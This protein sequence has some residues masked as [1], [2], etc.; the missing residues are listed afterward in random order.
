MKL[1]I[2]GAGRGKR[3]GKFT[4]RKPKILVKIGKLSLL[5]ILLK[6]STNTK[7]F[8]EIVVVVGY[9]KKDVQKLIVKQGFKN[10]R[11]IHNPFYEIFGP[12]ISL[13]LASLFI[14]D[15]FIIINGDTLFSPG[16]FKNISDEKNV[17]QLF[18]SKKERYMKDEMRVKTDRKGFLIKAD[19][20]IADINAD[21]VSLGI[22]VVKGDKNRKIIK[23]SIES[24]I[25]NPKNTPTYWHELLNYLINK[26]QPIKT[27]TVDKNCWIEIDTERDL[28]KAKKFYEYLKQFI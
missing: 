25:S 24:L 6:I 13:W 20:N 5:E 8:S 17:I 1:I 28:K 14:D 18:I 3:L 7:I 12:L 26:K 9:R 16:I 27:I 15:D 19:K 11:V 22:V 4:D 10:V 2:L 21:G 23:E